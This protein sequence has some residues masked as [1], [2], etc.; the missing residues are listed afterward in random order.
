MNNIYIIH[1]GAIG[2]LVLAG[3]TLAAVRRAWPQARITLIGQPERTVLAQAAG[4]VDACEDFDTHLARPAPPAADLLVD[5]LSSPAAAAYLGAAKVA[6]VHPI[7][8]PGWNRPA[9]AWILGETAR[10]LGLDAPADDR[11]QIPLP[12]ALVESARAILVER[13]VRG[14]FAAIHPGSG[15][16]AKNW[17]MDRFVEVAQRLRRTGRDV[18]WLVGPAERDRGTRPPETETVLSDLPLDLVAG[19]LTQADLYLGNDSG[20]THLAAA[21][22]GPG[23]RRTPTVA[24]FGPTDPQVWA[25]RGPH[26]RVVRSPDGTMDGLTLERAWKTVAD[27][28]K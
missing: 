10:Q 9:A 11:P 3:P 25:P 6:A 18:V 24:L 12:S 13:G 2:D 5:F 20:A 22:R 23:G 21:V 26:V 16:R 14:P 1:M 7:P 28:R 17:P 19:V 27:L 8:P 15:S 4:W